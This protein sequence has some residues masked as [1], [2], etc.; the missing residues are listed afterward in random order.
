MTWCFSADSEAFAIIGS[1]LFSS[2]FR[3]A[4]LLAVVCR[5]EHPLARLTTHKSRAAV[6][7]TMPKGHAQLLILP[8]VNHAEFGRKYKS[9]Y[10]DYH[11]DNADIRKVYGRGSV[12][13]LR[14]V[15]VAPIIN[16]C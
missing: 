7:K 1:M 8:T 12:G 11:A 10:I 5:S 14:V 4:L 3:L 2:S 9:V 15:V 16:Y 13:D 6:A